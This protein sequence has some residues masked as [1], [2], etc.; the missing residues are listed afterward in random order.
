MPYAPMKPC[1]FPG[2]GV[3]VPSTQRR[4]D[5]HRKQEENERSRH[6]RASGEFTIVFYNSRAWR[7]F[8]DAWL[9]EFPLCGDRP[10]GPSA[11]H[12]ACVEFGRVTPAAQVDHI[13][14][15]REGGDHFDRSNIQSLCHSCHSSKSMSRRMELKHG[16]WCARTGCDQRAQP[17]AEF[18]IVHQRRSV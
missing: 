12:S 17:G 4:C 8:R 14:A 1:T 7:S 16:P 9:R 11:E 15:V 13:E 6:R 2:C 18:C 10:A 3:L 5:A